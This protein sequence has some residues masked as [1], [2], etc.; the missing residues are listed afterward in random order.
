MTT[1]PPTIT[2]TAAGPASNPDYG[3]ASEPATYDE[4]LAIAS[5][6]NCG[7]LSPYIT[8][9]GRDI[10][11]YDGY[12]ADTSAVTVEYAFRT[13]GTG[14]KSTSWSLAPVRRRIMKGWM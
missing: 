1:A 6:E 7:I 13:L 11:Y 9:A 10:A 12:D 3:N 8:V 14:E 2:I 4:S 5:V